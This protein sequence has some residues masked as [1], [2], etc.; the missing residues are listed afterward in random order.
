MIVVICGFM[1]AG[2]S[3]LLSQFPKEKTIDLDQYILDSFPHYRNL[4]DLIDDKGM[5]GFRLIESLIL[6]SLLKGNDSSNL[7]IALGGGALNSQSLNLVK[8]HGKL[9]WLK[10]PLA[11]CLERIKE[12]NSLRPLAK[13]SNEELEELYLEREKFYSQADFTGKNTEEVVDIVTNLV[14]RLS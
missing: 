10:T 7:I 8:S 14:N 3:T 13:L 4:A 12:Q 11:E 6:A 1:A 2:K 5:Q 9:I